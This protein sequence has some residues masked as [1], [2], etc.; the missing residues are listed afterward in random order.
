MTA[1]PDPLVETAERL[2]ETLE[3]LGDAL[4]S[5]DAGTLL[6]TEESLGQ[7]LAALA[8]SRSTQDKSALNER[9]G[10]AA[11]ALVRCRRL[12]ASLGSVASARLR[13]RTGVAAYGPS[14]EYV[15]QSVS[16][17]AVRVAV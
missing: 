2:C 10:R 15:E 8:A 6:E 17:S 5:L 1:E 4:V 7:V 13:L 11:D 12:G 14:G 3:R 16:G 9:V